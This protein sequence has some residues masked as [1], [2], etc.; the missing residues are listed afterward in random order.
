MQKDLVKKKSHLFERVEENMKDRSKMATTI[1][2]VSSR[3][4]LK[5]PES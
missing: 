5:H 2:A 1:F 3:K 4:M